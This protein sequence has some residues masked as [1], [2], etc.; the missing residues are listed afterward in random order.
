VLRGTAFGVAFAD[1]TNDGRPDLMLA[2]GHVQDQIDRVDPDTGY[3]QPTQVLLNEGGTFRDVS[4][5]AGP[6]FQNRIVGRGLTVADFDRD[7]RL[8]ALV[9]NFAGPPQLL[10]N[11][12]PAGHWVSVTLSQPGPNRHAIGAR[13]TLTSGNGTQVRTLQTGRS[14]LSAAPAEAHFGTGEATAG[15]LEITWPDGR[16]QRTP[17]PAFDRRT[18]VTR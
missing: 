18:Q 16:R 6:S 7:G 14:Y 11:E 17:L 9:A 5:T 4:G 10:H 12:S 1:W 3:R 8:D 2:N 13:V 15:E